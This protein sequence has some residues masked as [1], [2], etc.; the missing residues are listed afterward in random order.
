MDAVFWVGE[1]SVEEVVFVPWGAEE[2]CVALRGREHGEEDL[3]DDF[4]DTQLA[5]SQIIMLAL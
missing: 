5:S 2:N 3:G 4:F 1:G